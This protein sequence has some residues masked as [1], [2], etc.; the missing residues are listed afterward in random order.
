MGIN[1]QDRKGGGLDRSKKR[2]AT[3]VVHACKLST[4]GASAMC[5]VQYV[6]MLNCNV[7]TERSQG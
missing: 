2:V 7:C 3:K 1:E 5:A 4:G 6:C